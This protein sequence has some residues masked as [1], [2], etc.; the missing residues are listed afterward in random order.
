MTCQY[1]VRP[2]DEAEI[3]RAYPL[4]QSVSPYLTLDRWVEYAR[5]LRSRGKKDSGDGIM[6][7]LNPQGYIFGI[8]CHVLEPDAVSGQIL[9]VSNFAAAN[10]CD[11]GDVVGP[12]IDSMS[13]IARARHCGAIHVDLADSLR[14][15]PCPAHGVFST[16]AAAGFAA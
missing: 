16:F 14:S 15:L 9:R 13:I 10:L 7:A 1:M 4:V 6:S 11:P 2:L 8:Y 3:P 5:S 12:L